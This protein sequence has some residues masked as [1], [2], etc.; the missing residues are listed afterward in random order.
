MVGQKRE[1]PYRDRVRRVQK[2]RNR[3]RENKIDLI[4]LGTVVYMAEC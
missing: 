1:F 2:D 4:F 3:A